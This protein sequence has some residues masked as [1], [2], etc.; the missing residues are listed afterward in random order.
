MLHLSPVNLEGPASFPGLSLPSVF[1]ASFPFHQKAPELS[2]QHTPV[3]A[4]TSITSLNCR[5]FFVVRTFKI[6]FLNLFRMSG[7]R[8]CAVQSHAM[9]YY[10]AL[11][12]KEILA[13]VIPWLDLEGIMLSETS[14]KDKNCTMSLICG[15]QKGRTPRSR[16]EQ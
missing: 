4:N 15:I 1:E 6:D 7:E 16:G 3:F 11:R 12:R 5:F 8:R 14:E 10:S 13:L 9:G 2:M